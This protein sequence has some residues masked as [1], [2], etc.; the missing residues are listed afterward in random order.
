MTVWLLEFGVIRIKSYIAYSHVS[1]DHKVFTLI[2]YRLTC[3]CDHIWKCVLFCEYF[4]FR[5]YMPSFLFA[6]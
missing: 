4:K 2:R 3:T 5:T 1:D 6:H